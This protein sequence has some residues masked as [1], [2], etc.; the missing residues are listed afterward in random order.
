MTCKCMCVC[1]SNYLV[2]KEGLCVRSKVEAR[3]ERR[4]LISEKYFCL[5]ASNHEEFGAQEDKK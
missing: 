1:V 2:P 4:A 5:L 3:E